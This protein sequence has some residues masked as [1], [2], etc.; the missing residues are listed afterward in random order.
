MLSAARIYGA[1]GRRVAE[2]GKDAWNRRV[3]IGR[4]EKLRHVSAAFFEAV[5]NKPD[6][7]AEPPLWSRGEVLI[8]IRMSQPIPPPPM[9]PL[10]DE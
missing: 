6:E 4:A 9:D 8:D 10:P 1:I 2:L 5:R 3:V 7:P